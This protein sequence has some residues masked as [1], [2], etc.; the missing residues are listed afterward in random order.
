MAAA[1]SS[2]APQSETGPWDPVD[3]FE[4]QRVK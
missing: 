2:L 3:Q 1:V 4:N